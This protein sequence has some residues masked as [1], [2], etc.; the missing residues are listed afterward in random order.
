MNQKTVARGIEEYKYRRGAFKFVLFESALIAGLLTWTAV[1][2]L[3]FFTY[4]FDVAIVPFIMIF[5]IILF[6]NKSNFSQYLS[7]VLSCIWGLIGFLFGFII[8]SPSVLFGF[9]IGILGFILFYNVTI[10]LRIKG[11]EH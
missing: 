10:K 9:I 11:Y 4:R 3:P 8:G 2:F 6:V 5:A 7:I 1:Y